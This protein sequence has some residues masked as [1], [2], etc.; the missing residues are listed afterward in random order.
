MQIGIAHAATERRWAHCNS[1]LNKA[2]SICCV[3]V[4]SVLLYT[5]YQVAREDVLAHVDGDLRFSL[6]AVE[7]Q[8]VANV[9]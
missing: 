8:L 9:S 2:N 5:I 3:I 4:S 1:A 6:G 7:G